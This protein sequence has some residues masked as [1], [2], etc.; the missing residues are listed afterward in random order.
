MKRNNKNRDS[1]LEIIGKSLKK[2][3]E[4]DEQE[5]K[6]HRMQKKEI[7]TIQNVMDRYFDDKALKEKL[8]KN[9]EASALLQKAK[10]LIAD[11]RLLLR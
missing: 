4:L 3:L 8:A 2:L 1:D 7:E 5:R 11:L 9:E 10:S 6:I